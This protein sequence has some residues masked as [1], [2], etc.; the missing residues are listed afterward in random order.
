M[1]EGLVV[2]CF[3]SGRV[4]CKYEINEADQCDEE[5][6]RVIW[7]VCVAIGISPHALWRIMQCPEYCLNI[8]LHLPCGGIVSSCGFAHEIWSC[9]LLKVPG[10]CNSL[11]ASDIHYQAEQITS[12]VTPI[13]KVFSSNHGRSNLEPERLQLLIHIREGPGSDFD[14]YTGYP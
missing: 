2:R 5:D 7:F 9:F 12:S 4:L 11:S 10:N 6:L 1:H 13:R 3:E 14:L 8:P